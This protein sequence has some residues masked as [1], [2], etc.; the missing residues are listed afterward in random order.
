[1][2]LTIHFPDPITARQSLFL[3][4]DGQPFTTSRAI[5][6]RFGK[7]HKDVLRAIKKM[8]KDI[9]DS[10]FWQR[11]FA[12]R[13]YVDDRGKT[14]LEYHLN[15]DGFAVLVMGFTGEQALAWKIAFLEAFNQ[16]ENELKTNQERYL[17]ALD[18]M[19]PPLR[20]IVEATKQG[21]NRK[22]IGEQVGKSVGAVTYHR[23][24]ARELG[25]LH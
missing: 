17:S 18:R 5:A 24:K 7:Q 16:M 19:H 3:S 1:M 15:H 11:N 8:L 23:R 13:D 12:P 6:E 2:Q 22:T 25:L 4:T 9:P 14:Y 21:Q 20:P 10:D